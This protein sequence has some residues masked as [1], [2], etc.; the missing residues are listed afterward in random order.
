M[1]LTLVSEFLEVVVTPERGGDIV[2]LTDRITGIQTLAESPTGAVES[3]AFAGGDS[4]VNWTNGYPGGWQ[5]MV[6]NAGP[7]RVHDGVTQGYHG[8]ASLARWAVLDC[9]PSSATLQTHLLTAPLMLERTI[10]LDGAELTVT[11]RVHNLSP[12][13]CSFRLGQHPAFGTPF[14]DNTSYVL[15]TARTLLADAQAPG[16]LAAP[17]A[18]GRPTDILAVGPV[19]HSLALPGPGTAEGLFAALTD[20]TPDSIDSE[21]TSATL[22]SPTHGFGMRLSWERTIYPHAWLWIEANSRRNWPWYQRLFAI[23]IEPANVLPGEGISPGGHHRG[24][25][26]ATLAACDTLTSTIRVT[27]VPLG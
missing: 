23:A 24:G 18:R 1:P 26:G 4:M 12:L 3:S 15:T 6:P 19:P 21:I 7:E 10:S 22:C 11:D 5:L 9:T 17:D 20:L 14:L 13:P 27:R 2:H 8:E 25:L 16:T